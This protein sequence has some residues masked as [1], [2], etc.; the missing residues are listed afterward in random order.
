MT[1]SR[2]QRGFS[3]IELVVA[4]VVMVVALIAILT[5]F[6]LNRTISRGQNDL[7]DLQQ[8]MR[9]SAR[10]VARRVRLG[11]RGGIAATK[12]FEVDPN[13]GP[14]T[15]IG[16]DTVVAGTDVLTVR[17][18]LRTPVY[19]IDA[20]VPT[21]FQIGVPGAG[22]AT[23]IIDSV[24]PS[25]FTQSIDSLRELEDGGVVQHEPIIL[26]SRQTD[27]IYAVV[28][29]DNITFQDDLPIPV[30]GP[31]ATVDR[32]TLTLNISAGV[33]TNT[34]EYL[35]LSQNGVFPPTLTTVLFAGVLEEYR[36]FVRQEYSI[37]GDNTSRPSPKLSL[38]RMVPGTDTVHPAPDSAAQDI[39]DNI[40]DLQVALGIDLDEDGRVDEMDGGNPLPGNADEWR[41]NHT[42]DVADPN[43]WDD[44]PLRL[45]RFSLLGRTDAP[46]IARLVARP[47]AAIEDHVYSEAASPP[48]EA[49]ALERRYRR[50]MLQTIVDLRNL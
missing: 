2:S 33:G 31:S 34:A 17:G 3:M 35:L 10:E 41:W 47:I 12:A 29:L 46:E 19:R 28:E 32:A 37:P 30:L 27:A 24:S 4:A 9:I 22:Q 43:A 13:V 44:D 39:A 38:T 40:L 20:S 25:G 36:F 26:V 15:T 16:S 21:N 49:A 50:W 5:A 7:A 23:L 48:N 14:G 45:V 11:G 8:S 1:R 42:G 18:A 6:D